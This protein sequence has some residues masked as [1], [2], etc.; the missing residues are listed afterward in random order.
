MNH[1]DWLLARRRALWQSLPHPE[2]AKLS[3]A[4][5][6]EHEQTHLLPMVRPFDGCADTYSRDFWFNSRAQYTR[7]HSTSE[8]AG[9]L[10]ARK[11]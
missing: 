4:E 3:I 7:Q 5:M 2:Y 11:A 6:L 10:T 8:N 9:R 1:P